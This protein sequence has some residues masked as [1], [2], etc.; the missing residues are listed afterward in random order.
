MDTSSAPRETE[1]RVMQR[2]A[3]TWRVVATGF[4][5]LLGTSQWLFDVFGDEPT[6]TLRVERRI[7]AQWFLCYSIEPRGV[8]LT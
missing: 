8:V 2:E 4:G 1:Y 5:G 6:A 3:G 7:G